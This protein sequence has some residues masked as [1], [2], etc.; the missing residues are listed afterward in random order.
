MKWIIAFIIMVTLCSCRST[1]VQ[2]EYIE[3]E[4]HSFSALSVDSVANTLSLSFDTLDIWYASDSQSVSMTEK[5]KPSVYR[6]RMVN[7]K[8][9][10]R[11][12]EVI[13]QSVM[14]TTAV[15]IHDEVLKE[16]RPPPT[17]K[18]AIFIVIVIFALLIYLAY[19]SRPRS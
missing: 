6:V 12:E 8:V 3:K 10:N 17:D 14:D 5:E 13:T 16:K 1:Q 18:A 11:K 2:H 4:Q 19:T 7:G 15:V 9:E